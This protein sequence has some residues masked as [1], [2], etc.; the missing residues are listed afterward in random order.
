MS[1]I[2]T[3]DFNPAQRVPGEMNLATRNLLRVVAA[4]AN[5]SALT[6]LYTDEDGVLGVRNVK[7]DEIY[8][9][10]KGN[11]LVGGEDLNRAEYRQ[12]DIE[13]IHFVGQS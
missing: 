6:F 8:R 4:I 5:Q 13:R 12:F 3:Q 7:P 10:G 1:M 9:A 2:D 11:T